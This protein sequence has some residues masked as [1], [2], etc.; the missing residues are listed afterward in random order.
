MLQCTKSCSKICFGRSKPEDR[1]QICPWNLVCY[2]STHMMGKVWSLWYQS[3]HYWTELWTT[4]HSE[5]RQSYG[6]EI[7]LQ[8]TI[9]QVIFTI[10]LPTDINECLQE[11]S[12]QP[13][14]IEQ[15]YDTIPPTS[16]LTS[17]SISHRNKRL[18]FLH[19]GRSHVVICNDIWKEVWISASSSKCPGT[20]WCKS[21]CFCSSNSIQGRNFDTIFHKFPMVSKLMA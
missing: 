18:C 12:V 10:H 20:H 17:F 5:Q 7:N 1:E 15:T 13:L 3:W 14:P 16:K 2:N 21:N 8:C 19:A 4:N 9:L 11:M 6:G